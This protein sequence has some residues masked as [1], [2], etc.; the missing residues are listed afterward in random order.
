MMVLVPFL[1]NS[2]KYQHQSA[3]TD[4]PKELSSSAQKKLHDILLFQGARN[5]LNISFSKANTNFRSN[6]REYL[7]V[8]SAKDG[9]RHLEI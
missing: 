7:I 1:S 4:K 9:A 2:K 6:G 8:D 3:T 5:T